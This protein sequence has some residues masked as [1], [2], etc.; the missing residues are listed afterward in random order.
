MT[1]QFFIILISLF[2]WAC[3][4]VVA[5][6]PPMPEVSHP[7]PQER[8][9][10]AMGW[11]RLV[12]E[13][14]G[15][16][17]EILWKGPAGP[18][19]KGAILILH[20]GGGQYFQWCV[21]NVAFLEPQVRFSNQ[22]LDEGFAV[23]LLNSTD[24][25]T[26]NEGRSCGKVWDDEVRSRP[27]VDLPFIEEIIRVL[28]PQVRPQG[29]RNEIFLTGLSSGGYM[30]VRAATHLDNLIT[31]FAPVSSGDP[32]GWHRVCERNL[33]PRQT[34]FG[35]GFDNET[36]KQIPEPD[37]CRAIS[38]PHER[39]WGTTHQK[40]KPAFRIFHHEKDGI[41]DLSCS[42]KVDGLLRQHGYSGEPAF[43]LKEDRNRNLANHLWQNTYNRPIL[44]FFTRQLDKN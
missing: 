9:C 37:A 28:I 24:K 42:E 29:S 31:A 5:G 19:A 25:V 1:N 35:A 43:L 36:G 22:A 33:S 8:Q 40:T 11:H 18:W 41:H 39:P 20:G 30:T 2:L 38:Y 23:F 16:P 3:G 13:I 17:R 26:D 15:L 12:M 32:Y 6:P 14:A 21:A 7:M 4:T 34:V 10:L 44:E 27:N